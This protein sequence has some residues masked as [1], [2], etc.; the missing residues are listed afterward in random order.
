ME[1]GPELFCSARVL[2]A[3]HGHIIL[4]Q[5]ATY[6]RK[7]W[8]WGKAPKSRARFPTSRRWRIGCAVDSQLD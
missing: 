6:D 8:S 2:V 5:N 4:F 7:S 3:H 1:T